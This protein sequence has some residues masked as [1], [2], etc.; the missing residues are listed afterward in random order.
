M[1]QMFSAFAEFERNRIRVRTK[2]EIERAKVQGKKLGRLEAHKTIIA[3]QAKKASGLSQSN[4][5]KELQL[6]IATVKGY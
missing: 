5:A 3:V 4:M 1:L 2:E 6:S